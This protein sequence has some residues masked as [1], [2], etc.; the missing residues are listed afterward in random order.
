MGLML[1][2]YMNSFERRKILIH[3]MEELES[4]GM[5]CL[6]C[7]GT[8]CTFEANSMMIEPL[9]AFEIISYLKDKNLLNDELKDQLK[10][11]VT[12]FRLE[13]KP[14]KGKSYLRKTYT[15]PFFEYQELGCPLPREIKPYGCLAFDSHHPE[16]KASEHCY[17][18]V[19]L[20]ERIDNQK[21]L[22]EEIKT[23]YQ[24]YWDKSPIPTALLDL[25]D[26]INDVNQSPD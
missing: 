13:H 5:G 18:E 6:G 3:R 24:L 9:E 11:S 8:C 25:W 16:L 22:N 2:K 1:A 20:L 23:K 10:D 15:C 21:N 14:L 19:E 17:S 12:K 7:P 26:K 4:Q